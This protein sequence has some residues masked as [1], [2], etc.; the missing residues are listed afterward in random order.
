MFNFYFDESSHDRAITYKDGKGLNIYLPA[1][2][3]LFIGVFWGFNQ[4][5]EL[6]YKHQY[7]IIE[8]YFKN[9][10]RLKED[11]EFKGE[12][13]KQKNF[14]Y[15]FNSLKPNSIKVYSSLFQLIDCEE[16]ILHIH[17]YSKTEYLLTQYFKEIHFTPGLINI[18]AFI[19]SLT[20][21]LFNYRNEEFLSRLFN[22]SI[23]SSQHFLDEL[24]IIL[25]KVI[26]NITPVPRK[27]YELPALQQML[28]VLEGAYIKT[29]PREKYK[30]DYN[31]L[32][33]GISKLL[34]E[35]DIKLDQVNIR[36][37]PEGTHRIVNSAKQHEFKSVIDDENSTENGLIRVADLLSNMFYR[38]TLALYEALKEDTFVNANNHDYI[39]KHILN[40]EWF[41][42]KDE[43]IYQ[44][45]VRL[46]RILTITNRNYWTIFSGI[47]FDYALIVFSLIS[48]IGGSHSSFIHFKSITGK[49]HAEYFNTFVTLRLEEEFQK[50]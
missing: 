8:G 42:I 1:R 49:Q 4:E 13:I 25:K 38:L 27:K 28:L 23:I 6:N 19:Y 20:K 18:N 3:D 12:I 21:F 43:K 14:K 44:L 41:T 45:Y 26:K 7:S 9:I 32:F 35:L 17:L 39:T 37:D 29:H 22:S 10:Y 11:Q 50:M 2:N 33:I 47:Y 31:H 16:V 48:Y 30:W 46:N 24:K 36:I 15:G 40:E 34:E 5:N